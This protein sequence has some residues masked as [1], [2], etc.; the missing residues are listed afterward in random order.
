MNIREFQ[1]RAGI[2]TE[3]VDVNAV[4]SELTRASK[5]E[6]TKILSVAMAQVSD[7]YADKEVVQALQAAYDAL[8]GKKALDEAYDENIK[9]EEIEV[10][11]DERYG[12][13]YS[14][15]AFS[16]QDYDKYSNE[17]IK[18]PVY[19]TTS[20]K[21]AEKY[22]SKHSGISNLELPWSMGRT[23]FQKDFN[24]LKAKLKDKGIDIYDVQF[25]LS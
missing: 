7:L 22:I 6:L 9:P 25:D 24:A 13:F 8:T 12:R 2:M 19:R 20:I 4:A 11:Y 3:A 18:K 1:R 23:D 14:L 5:E 15:T 16:G 21:D 10:T 17:P